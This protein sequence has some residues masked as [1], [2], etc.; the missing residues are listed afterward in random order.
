MMGARAE[1]R[2]GHADMQEFSEV[3]RMTMMSAPVVSIIVPAYNAVKTLKKCIDSILNQTLTDIEVIII[4]DGSVDETRT[5]LTDYSD[6][7]SRV[8]VINKDKNEGLVAARKTGVEIASG[9]YVGFVD[10]DDWIESDMFESLYEY[11]KKHSVDMVSSG[12]F[13]EGNYTSIC[14][15]GIDEGI[16][17][18]DMEYVRDSVF[19]VLGTNNVGVRSPV[20]NKLFR[21]CVLEKTL[22]HISNKVT[23]CE[24]KMT[25]LSFLLEARSIYV[26]YKPFYHYIIQI[27][28][29]SH[30]RDV[31]YLARI[32][33]VYKQIVSF[34]DHPNFTPLMRQQAEMYI[35]EMLYKGINSR[36]GF[37]N[38]NLLWLDPYWMEEFAEGT[39]FVLYG[40]GDL[41]RAYLNQIE[42]HGGFSYVGCIDF[43][44]ER[45]NEDAMNPQSPNAVKERDYDYILITIKNSSKAEEVRKDLINSGIPEEKIKW[46]DQTEI[47]WKFAKYN[48]KKLK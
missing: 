34:Y 41:G 14:C 13:L 12:Y 45:L 11:A 6:R 23:E 16:H 38:K 25:L 9:E 21:K 7:D 29:M 47:F 26:S 1:N 18:E 36:L 22:S 5:L 17:S 28:S 10:S 27:N 15:D 48:W 42:N 33:N 19:Y 46:F 43:G 32:D 40:A 3:D 2:K 30:K 37:A 31:D 24:D 4:N 39:K 35:T 44:Y 8:R 20:W